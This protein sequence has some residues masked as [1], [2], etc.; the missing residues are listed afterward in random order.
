MS[1]TTTIEDIQKLPHY[2]EYT[3]HNCGH[4]QKAYILSIYRE[5]ENCG[6]RSKLRRY[7]SFGA[8]VEDIVDI[9]LEWLGKGEDLEQAL[10]R[11]QEI[12]QLDE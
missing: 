6:I 9:V 4:K 5:C 3:C 7:A 12:D 10:L 2:R 1:Y 11:K 8:E